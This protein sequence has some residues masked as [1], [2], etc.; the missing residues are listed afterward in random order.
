MGNVRYVYAAVAGLGVALAVLF[1]II[2]L[3]EVS[4]EELQAEEDLKAEA[5]GMADTDEQLAKPF[6]KQL[7]PILGFVAQFM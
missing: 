4:E 5:S 1:V 7:R 3:P 2:K 6:F